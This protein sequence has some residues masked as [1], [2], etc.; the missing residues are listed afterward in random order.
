MADAIQDIGYIMGRFLKNTIKGKWDETYATTIAEEYL[1]PFALH[2]PKKFF[3]FHEGALENIWLD[4]KERESSSYFMKK[5]DFFVVKNNRPYLLVG[6]TIIYPKDGEANNV[7]PL[8]ITPLYSGVR[9]QFN[10]KGIHVVGGGYVESF[11][12][13]SKSSKEK[14]R[15][16]D[17]RQEFKLG[18]RNILRFSLADIVGTSGAAPQQTLLKAN[19]GVL[20]FPEY[21]H[22]PVINESEVKSRE[23]P[24]GDG[25]HIDN[26]GLMPLLVRQVQNILVFINTPVPF[27]PNKFEGTVTKKVIVDDLISYF[28]KLDNLPH[29]VVFEEEKLLEIYQKFKSKKSQN[30]SN[31][32]YIGEPLVY[33]DKYKIKDNPWYVIDSYEP[34]ICW[35]YLDK[36]GGWLNEI[37]E[38]M[39]IKKTSSQIINNKKKFKNFPHFSTFVQ[40]KKSLQVIDLDKRAVNLL[41][42]LTAWTVIK[43]KEYINSKLNIQ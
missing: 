22:W 19:V 20:G 12:Y 37:T 5:S 13:D 42:N 1:K 14:L 36:T 23:L 41:S 28:K 43:S 29:N 35:V 31:K 30:L 39:K 7:Y 8:E 26:L 33:C 10:V 9:R 32:K 3:T 16:D 11:A 21:K 17:K 38:N 2:S 24:H 6:G 34:N 15:T 18:W 40:E 25:G 27:S 4:N